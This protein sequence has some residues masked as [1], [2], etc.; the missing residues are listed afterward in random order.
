MES[1]KGAEDME[2]LNKEEFFKD[3]NFEIIS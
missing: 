1:N 2:S 3:K